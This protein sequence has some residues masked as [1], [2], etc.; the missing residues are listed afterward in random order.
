VIN[1]D[2]FC[3]SSLRRPIAVLSL[4]GAMLLSAAQPAQAQYFG[5]SPFSGLSNVSWLARSLGY[6]LI[7]NSGYNAPYYLANSLVWNASYAAS[8]GLGFSNN[9]QYN[10][11]QYMDP[12]GQLLGQ[13]RSRTKATAT[14]NQAVMDQSVQANW[15][16]PARPW[17]Q[18]QQSQDPSWVPL[19]Q[20][21]NANAVPE[22][23][24]D[25][26][27]APAANAPQRTNPAVA[28]APTSSFPQNPFAANNA[29]PAVASQQAQPQ[30]SANF[31][32][33]KKPSSGWFNKSKKKFGSPVADATN[34]ASAADIETHESPLARGFLHLVNENYGGDLSRALADA[35]MRKYA[36]AIG[37][38]PSSNESLSQISAERSD[39]IRQILSDRSQDAS[40]RLNAARLLLKS[41]PRSAS[42]GS[43]Q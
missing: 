2:T 26:P 13:G 23:I 16:A 5:Y 39:L 31:T 43:A 21:N 33:N 10:S 8:R 7:R 24:P 12:S 27:F 41:T 28:S 40:V 34:T 30:D 36:K 22:V 19:S 3:L 9:R 1:K 38:I 29:P 14:N 20:N 4:L 18:E 15:I 17:P 32:G 6:P 37:L 35:D 25:D 11:G 42:V